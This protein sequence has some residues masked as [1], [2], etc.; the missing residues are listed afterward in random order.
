MSF[1]TL[2]DFLTVAQTANELHC[3]PDTVAALIRRGQ[4]KAIRLGRAVR[5][6]TASLAALAQAETPCGNAEKESGND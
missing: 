1:A 6:V 2:P 4:L 5:V 3:H